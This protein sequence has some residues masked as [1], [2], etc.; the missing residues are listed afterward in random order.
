PDT[1]SGD[2]SETNAGREKPEAHRA[3][4]M[5]LEEFRKKVDK[6]ILADSKMSKEDF[7]KFMK[8]YAELVKRKEKAAAEAPEVIAPPK[9]G[10]TLPTI[11][12]GPRKTTGSKPGDLK[13]DGRAE[14][15]PEYRE[16]NADFIRRLQL[17]KK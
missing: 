13:N 2:R 5:Q 16:R 3:S 6:D 17:P 4:T 10:G 11:A 12:G 1:A 14:P 8:D 15:P 7:E 9:P